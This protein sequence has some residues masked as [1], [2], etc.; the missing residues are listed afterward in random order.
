MSA[1]RASR[2]VRRRKRASQAGV[3][4]TTRRWRPRR[5]ERSTPRRAMRGV[6]ERARHPGRGGGGGRGPCPRGAC[7]AGTGGGLGRASRPGQRPAR[8]PACGCHGGWPRSTRSPAACRRHRR[9]GAAWSP[10]GRG[11]WGSGRSSSQA[12]TAPF[13]GDRG[14][15]D[16]RPAPVELIR[17]GQPLEQHLAQI[18]QYAS[19]MP[20]PQ[21]APARHARAAEALA[22][23]HRP[24][25]T[26]AQHEHDAL[27]GRAVVAARTPALRLR[28][29][30]RQQRLHGRP[31][32][33][34][35]KR[36]HGP[37]THQGR[38]LVQ[39]ISPRRTPHRSD[40]PARPRPRRRGGPRPRRAARRPG[41]P[42]S[43]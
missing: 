35:H 6:V 36:S 19:F 3:R 39:P 1:R 29:L 13:C 42:A 14:A 38:V 37:P 27:Q 32:P 4:P 10:A 20:V 23:Q 28:G 43:A 33:I 9:Q 16:R 18:A 7:A 17:R 15:V 31:Q 40:R 21:P 24:W 30:G 26:R 11:P 8:P 5:S 2:I 22:R 12:T 41:S 34:A 25:D